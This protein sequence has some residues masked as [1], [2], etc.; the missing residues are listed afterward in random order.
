MPL[1]MA[2]LEGMRAA[3]PRVLIYSMDK[4]YHIRLYLT[5]KPV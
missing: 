3:D 1:M 5:T 4:D 2:F